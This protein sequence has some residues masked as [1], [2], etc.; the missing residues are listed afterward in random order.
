MKPTL[1][2]QMI[3]GIGASVIRGN[4]SLLQYA[5]ACEALAKAYCFVFSVSKKCNSS[6][7]LRDCLCDSCGVYAY[8][9]VLGWARMC[10]SSGATHEEG[11]VNSDISGRVGHNTLKVCKDLTFQSVHPR[12][13]NSAL[14]LCIANFLFLAVIC[15]NVFPE[16]QSQINPLCS[17]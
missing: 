15:R 6:D 4:L 14:H 13:T 17:E 8:V 1:L 5:L 16:F 2:S 10:R 11:R 9:L 7:L 3:Y 12:H